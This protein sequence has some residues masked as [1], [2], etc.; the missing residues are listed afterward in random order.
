M[1]KPIMTREEFLV[2]ENYFNTKQYD[3]VVSY[4]SPDCT[5]EYM[6]HFT[7]GGQTPPQ[8]VHGP[9]EFVENYKTLHENVREFLDLGIFLSDEKNMIVEFQTEFH[10]LNDSPFQD[11]DVKRG[12]YFAVNQFCVYD[13]DENGKFS[14]IRISHFR[15]LSNDP[16]FKPAHSIDEA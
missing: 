6:D 9:A 8:T 15:V 10:Y 12:G 1:S 16:A 3:K 7:P 5:V 11:T 14:R 13:F 2:Y 4:F